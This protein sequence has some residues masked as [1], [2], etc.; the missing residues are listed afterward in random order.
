MSKNIQV[1][2]KLHPSKHTKHTNNLKTYLCY[3]LFLMVISTA[4]LS[5]LWI[6]LDRYE[7][8]TPSA[9]LSNYLKQVEQKKYE[10][11]FQQSGYADSKYTSKEDFIQYLES[12]YPDDLSNAT[13]LKKSIKDNISYYGVNIDG[14]EVSIL[15]LS[16]T[17]DTRYR[18]IAKTV[19]NIAMT[20]L[21]EAPEGITIEVNGE[22][23]SKDLII[24]TEVA[25]DNFMRLKDTSQAP[26]VKVYEIKGLLNEPEINAYDEDG[27]KCKVVKDLLEDRYYVSRFVSESDKDQYKALIEKVSKTYAKFISKDASFS[28]VSRYLYTRSSFYSDLSGFSNMWFS[29]HSSY[30]F[31]NI[32]LFDIQQFSDRDFTGTIT[33]D[34]LIKSNEVE[35]N[36]PGHYQLTFMKFNG[37]WKVVDLVSK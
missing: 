7:S 14:K 19:A 4:L 29:N 24:E 3:V 20:V 5:V 17:S 1:P 26:K 23:L 32:E 12:V 8:A 37:E 9:A 21:F 10:T 13:F 11:L 36:Y 15:S 31:Q 28:E 25:G 6:S 33:F 22:E 2:L 27:N 34:Y 18:Y 16:E 30:E 35:Q